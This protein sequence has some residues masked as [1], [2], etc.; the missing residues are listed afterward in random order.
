MRGISLFLKNDRLLIFES[1]SSLE[2][3]VGMRPRP[4][5]FYFPDT[6]FT[7]IR[8]RLLRL[9]HDLSQYDSPDIL[10]EEILDC[11]TSFGVERRASTAR[12][13]PEFPWSSFI[14]DADAEVNHLLPSNK[15][16]VKWF[17][18]D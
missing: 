15:V 5:N 13:I 2:L 12:E 1:P 18:Y 11:F 16:S 8:R 4:P 7:G 9:A 3:Q 6:S 14:P 17:S 10:Y